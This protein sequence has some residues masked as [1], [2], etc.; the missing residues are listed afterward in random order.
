[1]VGAAHTLIVGDKALSNSN[2]GSLDLN[3]LP[4]SITNE[5]EA[6]YKDYADNLS[7]EV[8]EV[9]NEISRC[10]SEIDRINVSLRNRRQE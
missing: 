5:V 4:P 9:Y 10:Q 3:N 7:K 1:M 6:L 2:L 8:A